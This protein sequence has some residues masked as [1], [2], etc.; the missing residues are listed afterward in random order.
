MHNFIG[1]PY[2]DR[3]DVMDIENYYLKNSGQFFIA[4]DVNDNQLIGTIAIENRG[5]YGILKRFYVK[6]NYQRNGMGRR[7]FNSLEFYIRETN[8]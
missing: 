5:Q 3:T 6:E 7:L 1:R 4:Y 8:T 2:K